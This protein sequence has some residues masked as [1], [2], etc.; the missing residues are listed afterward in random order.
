MKKKILIFAFLLISSTS[1]FANTWKEL[2][3]NCSN[4]VNF[5]GFLT[6]WSGHITL[7]EYDNNG[8]PTGNTMVVK[9]SDDGNWDWHWPWQ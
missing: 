8:N 6:V 3:N 1:V 5:L 9:C 4:R 2:S 7:G